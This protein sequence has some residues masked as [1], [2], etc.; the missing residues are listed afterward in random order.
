MYSPAEKERERE[1]ERE[2]ESL[3]SKRKEVGDYSFDDCSLVMTLFHVLSPSTPSSSNTWNQ[4]ILLCL[5]FF[6][7]PQAT[8]KAL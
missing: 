1:R 4:S 5:S 2:R 7:V 6:Y 3:F 8:S